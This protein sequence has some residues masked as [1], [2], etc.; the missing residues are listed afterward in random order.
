MASSSSL[1]IEDVALKA[2]YHQHHSSGTECE[3]TFTYPLSS[4]ALPTDADE[5]ATVSKTA[6]LSQLRA[7]CARL[8]EDVN[9]FLT[10]RMEGEKKKEED[11]DDEAEEENYGEEG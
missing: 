2:T 3:R 7:F 1:T 9:I 8:Q 10:E 11:D 6:Y 4:S 5:D